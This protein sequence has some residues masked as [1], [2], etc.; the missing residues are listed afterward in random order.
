MALNQEALSPMNELAV[1]L[2]AKRVDYG[3]FKVPIVS[4]AVSV[5]VLCQDAA[6]SDR[7]GI[8][9][10]FHS[11]SISQRNAVSH[12]KEIF[13][14]SRQ[15]WFVFVASQFLFLNNTRSDTAICRR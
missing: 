15:P 4:Q 11:D 7:V 13:L 8:I 5:E 6:M 1:N 10:E 14:H 9:L 2:T 12:V 3:Y